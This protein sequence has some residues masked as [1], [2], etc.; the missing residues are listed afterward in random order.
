MDGMR[1]SYAWPGVG[2]G[3]A[4]MN[5]TPRSR[6]NSTKAADWSQAQRLLLRGREGQGWGPRRDVLPS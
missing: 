5:P 2:T 1:K 4:I 3:F 6:A